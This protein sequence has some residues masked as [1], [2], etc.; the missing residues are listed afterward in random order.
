MFYKCPENHLEGNKK[1]FLG[2]GIAGTGILGHKLKTAT[3]I[4]YIYSIFMC[5]FNVCS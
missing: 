4:Y 3:R 2:S 1:L 5:T